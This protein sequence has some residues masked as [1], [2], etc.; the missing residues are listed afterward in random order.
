MSLLGLALITPSIA[1]AQSVTPAQD[2]TGTIVN[3]HGQRIDIE[4]GSPSANGE[5]LF[6]SFHTFTPGSGEI[7]NFLAEPTIQSIFA[8]VVGGNPAIIDGLLQISNSQASLFLMNPAGVIFGPNATLNL[9]AGLT[10]T[11]ADRIGFDEQWFNAVGSNEY[12]ALVGR[13]HAFAFTQPQPGA[14]L[15]QGR[16][17]LGPA[18]T[19]TLLGGTVINTG[20]LSA[21]GGQITIATVTGEQMVQIHQDGLLLNLEIAGPLDDGTEL[22]SI[23]PLSLPELLTY[24]DFNNANQLVANED[25]TVSLWGSNIAIPTA[26]GTA[27]AAGTLT[28]ANTT[29]AGTGGTMAILGEQVGLLNAE[30]DASGTNGGGAIF[31]GGDYQGQGTMPQATHTFVGEDVAIA[32]NAN[33]DGSGGQV[34]VWADHTTEFWGQVSATGGLNTGNGGFVEISGKENLIFRGDVDVTASAPNG[35]LGTLLLDPDDIRIVNGTGGLNDN[36]LADNQILF[37][38]GTG[39]FTLSENALES[40]MG[41]ANIELQANN[42]II[43]ENLADNQLTLAPGT[44]SITWTADAD[45]NGIGDITMADTNDTIS[46]A[47]RDVKFLGENLQLGTITTTAETSGSLTLQANRSINAG[48]L[49]TQSDQGTGGNVTVTA[50]DNLTIGNILT[51]GPTK[52]GNVNITNTNT[53]ISTNIGNILT[54]ANNGV[55]GTVTLSGA[56]GE[57]GNVTGTLVTDDS[58][59]DN[60]NDFDDD[61]DRIDEDVE[62][63]LETVDEDVDGFADEFD[64]TDDSLISFEDEFDDDGEFETDFEDNGELEDGEFENGNEFDD[65]FEEDDEFD[66]EF[67]EDDELDELPNQVVRTSLRDNN[68]NR[69]LTA[70]E[71][72]RAQEFSNYFGRDLNATELSP[73]QLQQLLTQVQTQTDNRSVIVYVKAPKSPSIGAATSASSLELLI[74]TASAE[75]VSLTI[76]NVSRDELFQTIGQFRSTLITSVRR[77]SKSYLKPAQQLYQWLIKPIEDELGKNAIDTILF[78]MDSGLRSLPIAALHDGQ[79]FLVEKYSVGMMPSLGLVNT[80]YQPLD[81]SQVLAMGASD[82][83]VLQPLPAVPIEIDVINQLWSGQRFLN[84][85][86]TRQNLVQQ[87]QQTP[88]QIIHLATHAEFKPGAVDNSYIQL[89]NE[90]LNLDDIHTL[91]WDRPVVDLL[92]LSACRTAVGNP[93]AELGFAGLAVASGVKSAMASLWTVDD[94][95]TLALMSEFYHQ[96]RDTPIKSGALRA[97]QLALLNSETRIESGQLQSGATRQAIALPPEIAIAGDVDFSHPY[98]W[99]GFTMIGSPW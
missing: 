30:L 48:N 31:I 58:F 92:V 82:F 2:G 42:N 22:P 66:D 37:G 11:T 43:L 87:Q 38:D 84:E 90:Q 52:S 47:G 17:S 45:G 94:V 99:S 74:F 34:I 44:G 95:G 63:D 23:T 79:Q 15:N 1:K 64:E 9:P 46:A 26:P 50:G 56:G 86:F 39:T 14:V 16:L 3:H 60:S 24:G 28:V 35:I 68:A 61:L 18:Q 69:A 71:A 13:P 5:N 81:G 19:L 73:S 40:L 55:S 78:S 12:T 65:E 33:T 6:H 80:Q 25:G 21:P 91:G 10:V 70:F 89:W 4:A 88:F 51:A 36:E 72:Q 20:E 75:P 96:L 29:P 62:D 32:A 97:A 59:V 49:I 67:E 8:R 85:T 57:L 83:S 76:P 53:N 98:Y 54:E 7:V 93:D 77:G 41:N 27:I